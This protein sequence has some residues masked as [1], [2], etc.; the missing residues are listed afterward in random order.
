M[1]LYI[2]GAWIVFNAI[3]GFF[4]VVPIEKSN[5]LKHIKKILRN[6]K[7]KRYP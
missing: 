7:I 3:V 4:L 1:F 6:I 2:V 5:Y